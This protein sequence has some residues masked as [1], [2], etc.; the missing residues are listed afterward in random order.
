[1]KFARSVFIV[2]GI[3]GIAVLMPFYWLVDLTGRRYAAPTEYPHFFYG[4]FAVAL[5]WQIAFLVIGY[6]PDRYRSLMILAMLEKFGF[7]ATLLVL[8]ARTRIPWI[9]AQAAAPDFVLGVLFIVA[10]VKTRLVREP[11]I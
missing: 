3:W 7:V 6:R 2:A 5:A 8:Y 11:G 4:F 10:F 9:D 1:M